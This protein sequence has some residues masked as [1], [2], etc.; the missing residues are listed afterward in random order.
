MAGREDLAADERFNTTEKI[1]ANAAE[2][3]EIVAD[4]LARRTYAEWLERFQGME[5]QRAAVQDAWEVSQIRRCAP[6][7]ASRR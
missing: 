5:G 4:V 1:M 2:A 7:A 6:T 3:A